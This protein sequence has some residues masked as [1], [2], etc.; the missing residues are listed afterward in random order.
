MIKRVL[1]TVWLGLLAN[2]SLASDDHSNHSDDLLLLLQHKIA[3]TKLQKT[4]SNTSPEAQLANHSRQAQHF[5][6]AL[7]SLKRFMAVPE[8]RYPNMDMY[9]QSLQSRSALLNDYAQLLLQF[10]AQP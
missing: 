10:H 4:W 2:A 7:P 3:I 8:S 1:L 5:K 6:V 9:A